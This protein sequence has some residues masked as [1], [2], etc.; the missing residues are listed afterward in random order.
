MMYSTGVTSIDAHI[1]FVLETREL[2][3]SRYTS[4]IHSFIVR[5]DHF[6]IVNQSGN[7]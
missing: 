3:V 1:K 4:I 6:I 7:M 2:R 5:V